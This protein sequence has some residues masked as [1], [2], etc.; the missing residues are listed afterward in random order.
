MLQRNFLLFFYSFCFWA[1][2]LFAQNLA[3]KLDGH[4]NNVRT[5]IGFL[6]A[7]WTI[8]AWIKGDDISWKECEVVFG[9]GEY[10]T[11]RKADN[12]PLVVKE[13]KLFCTKANI[14]SDT[15]M[16]D[17]WHHVAVSCS[18]DSVFLYVDGKVEACRDTSYTI[19]PGVIGASEEAKSV[20]GGCVD[21]VRIWREALSSK[22]IENWMYRPL[23]SNHPYYKELVAYYPFDSKLD[24]TSLNWVGS[25]YHSYHIRNGR[26]DYSGT[27]PLAGSV[28]NTND[29]F[30]SYSG[31]QRI[32]NLIS[33]E[34]EWDSD[35]G[36][37]NEQFS[38][39]RIAA[40][41]SKAPLVLESLELDLD[42]TQR[43]A[44]IDSLYIY[45]S[46]KTPRDSTR[47]L[48]C[49]VAPK[50][51]R[52]IKLSKDKQIALTDGINYLLVSADISRRARHGNVLGAVIS[53]VTLGGK[54]YQVDVRRNDVDKTVSENSLANS[55]IFR[56]LQWNIWH[57]GRH[58]PIEGKARI[59]ELIKRSNADI[60]TL[61]EGYGF[62]EE[63]A[64]YLKFNLQTASSG[65]NLALF[66]R[67]PIEKLKSSDTFRSNPAFVELPHSRRLLVNDC[68]VSYSYHPDYTGSFSDTGHNPNIWV[69]EDSIR[70]MANTRD[71]VLKDVCEALNGIDTPVVLGGDFNSYSHLDW[72]DRTSHL[73]AGYGYVPF[74][75]SL[76]LMEQGYKDSYRVVNPDELKRPEGT[77]AGIYG[78][79]DFARCDFIYYKG[80]KITPIQSKII[81][82]SP[83]IDDIWASDHSAVLTTFIWK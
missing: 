83:E 1:N 40:Q 7:P 20:F 56:I 67:F 82:T 63:M 23:Y 9:G 42:R 75:T 43:L 34:S 15:W 51:N 54:T 58:V 69:A 80:D 49:A 70:P 48:L 38:K 57:G 47:T 50:R 81:Q 25:G 60:V 64:E 39:L 28:K 18:N 77:F 71:F 35:K 17:S 2:A 19:I 76:Y 8:E 14:G 32:F 59:V 66:S 36:A 24:D 78:Q 61:Q 53:K 12:F 10:S 33:I 27:L 26:I 79:L 52:V 72:T 65:D 13:G 5:G 74:P 16:D 45:Y 3:I 44:D 29:K 46:G 68:W 4:D 37:K 41:G 6:D 55:D 22:D 73:H 62:Q 21:E 11:F 31:S 30:V